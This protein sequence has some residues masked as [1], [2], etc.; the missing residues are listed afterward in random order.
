[1][2]Q[3]WNSNKAKGMLMIVSIKASQVHDNDFVFIYIPSLKNNKFSNY[4]DHIYPIKLE[5]KD[6]AEKAGTASLI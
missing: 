6:S 2:C 3:Y 4:V 5:I 1:M